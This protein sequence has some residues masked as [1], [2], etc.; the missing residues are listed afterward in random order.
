[1]RIPND[2]P[3]HRVSGMPFDVLSCNT[4][5]KN[6]IIDD[7]TQATVDAHIDEYKQIHA[8]IDECHSIT[9]HAL[10]RDVVVDKRVGLG[11]NGIYLCS[12]LIY[13]A[14]PYISPWES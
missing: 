3:A 9:N 11:D 5:S 6:V 14:A 10:S 1:M 7:V 2:E 12:C 8:F 4:D 13:R